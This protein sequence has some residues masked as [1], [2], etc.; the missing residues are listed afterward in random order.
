MSH[1][2]GDTV[3]LTFTVSPDETPTVT[4]TSPDGTSTPTT[5]TEGDPGAYTALVEATASGTWT[6]TVT[7][8]NAVQKF[9]FVVDGADT[10]A[11][12]PELQAYTGQPPPDDAGRQLRRATQLIDEA[13]TSATYTVDTDGQPTDAAVVA[14]LRDATCAQVEYWTTGDEEDDIAGPLQGVVLG[15]MQL[16]YGAGSNR[17]TPTYLAPRAWRALRACPWIV[18]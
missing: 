5:P 14:A 12:R 6:L 3:R 1:D 18:W 9:A 17:A 2:V 11:T 10:Y 13:L 16:Q 4:V 7:T 8:D 15:G